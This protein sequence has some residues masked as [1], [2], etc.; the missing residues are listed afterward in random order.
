MRSIGYRCN[1]C[2]AFRSLNAH[3]GSGSV[4]PREHEARKC[5]TLF[6]RFDRLGL[7]THNADDVT[8]FS[9]GHPNPSGKW[10]PFAI[11]SMNVFTGTQPSVMRA[12]F[13]KQF[14]SREL[15]VVFGGIATL[16]SICQLLW[17]VCA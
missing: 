13:S 10:M 11:G 5:A 8:I 7:S 1:K 3:G 9:A 2:G 17:S 14:T 15:G 4:L 12:M 16:E 6:A